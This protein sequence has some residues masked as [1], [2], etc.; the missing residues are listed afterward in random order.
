M[1]ADRVIPVLVSG[2][3]AGRRIPAN[4]EAVITVDAGVGVNGED[5]LVEYVR[6]SYRVGATAAHAW[7]YRP[8]SDQEAAEAVWCWLLDG[9]GVLA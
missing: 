2:P 8:L 7:V 9:A 1:T 5:L 6:R 4:G 3:R